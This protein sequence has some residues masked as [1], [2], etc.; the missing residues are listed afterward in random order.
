M[1]VERT[2]EDKRP[3]DPKGLNA[4]QAR[5]FPRRYSNFSKLKNSKLIH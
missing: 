3:I 1:V 4:P 5:V 2:E